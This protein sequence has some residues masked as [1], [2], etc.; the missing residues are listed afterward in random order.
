MNERRF[1]PPWSVDEQ[2]A[3]FVVRDHNGQALAYI[4][5]RRPADIH[6]PSGELFLNLTQQL[7]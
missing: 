5:R 2:P 4:M 6:R 3:C 1:P 7:R